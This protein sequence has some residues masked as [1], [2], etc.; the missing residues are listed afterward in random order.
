MSL[1]ILY[2][3]NS[4][5]SFKTRHMVVMDFWLPSRTDILCRMLKLIDL[6]IQSGFYFSM[7]WVLN[8]PSSQ[9]CF[10]PRLRLLYFVNWVFI[11]SVLSSAREE[12]AFRGSFYV[13]NM[14]LQNFEMFSVTKFFRPYFGKTFFI[15]L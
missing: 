5:S 9:T 14:M 2:F 1:H 6:Q 10:S 8:Q 3:Q 12:E 11:S 13:N 15:F 7:L 4:K